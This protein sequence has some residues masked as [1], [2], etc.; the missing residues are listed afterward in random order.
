VRE[1]RNSGD[2]A[3]WV[4]LFILTVAIAALE[5][6]APLPISSD[7]VSTILLACG[8]LTCAAHFY[9]S[10]RPR[11]HFAVMCTSLCQ[12]I[13]FTV[14]GSLFSYLVAREGGPLWDGRLSAW[15]RFIGFDWL[16]YVR[17]L[18]DH[19]LLAG[20]LRLAYAS[21]IPQVVLVVLALGFARR[22]GSLRTVMLAAMACGTV[23]ILLSAFA[24]AAG[25]YAF[26]GLGPRN[27]QVLHRWA[28]EARDFDALRSGALSV[29]KLG[30]MQGIIIFP[31]YHAGLATITSW[32]FWVS[33]LGWVRWPGVIVGAATV[34][35]TPVDGGH[36]AVDVLAGMIVAAGAVWW[37][38]SAVAWQ[39]SPV[40]ALPFRRSR[41]AS[42]L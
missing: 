37:A 3:A 30:Q 21:L 38:R 6:R 15:D 4:L 32:G 41:A 28:A 11:E 14:L 25:N 40:R 2:A 7:G 39:P 19:P 23:T 17:W 16:R 35:A 10:V 9:R 22:V 31:S 20:A 33:R 29:V 18:D 13:L 1:Y 27:S 36:Y 5:M 24:P 34:A 8:G 26:L 42:G 12:V